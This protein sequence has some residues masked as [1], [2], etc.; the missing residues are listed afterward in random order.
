MTTVSGASI[1]SD[2]HDRISIRILRVLHS[3]L[4]ST[5]I[6]RQLGIPCTVTGTITA[7]ADGSDISGATVS[8]GTDSGTTA[9]DGTYTVTL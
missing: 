6:N 4:A 8:F 1:A 9:S 2:I 3:L 7:A 5:L